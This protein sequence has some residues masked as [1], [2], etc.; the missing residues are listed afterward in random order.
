MMP[1]ALAAQDNGGVLLRLNLSGQVEHDDGENNLRSDIGLNLSSITRNQSFRLG[2]SSGFEGELSDG[3]DAEVED[4]RV[5]L[6]YSLENR[7]TALS[8]NLAFQRSDIDDLTVTDTLTD[9]A[10]VVED[11][12]RQDSSAGFQLELGRENPFGATISLA[13]SETEYQDLSTP[14]T[15][16]QDSERVSGDLTLRFNLNQT[17]TLFTRLSLSDLDRDQGNDIRREALSASLDVELREDLTATADLGYT[18]VITD[19][20]T[21]R[22]ER[23]GIFYGLSLVADR[24][25]GTLSGLLDSDITENGRR[26]TLQ[27][28]RLYELPNGSLS[29]SV[30]ASRNSETNST[31]PL[32][33]F[34]YIQAL[35]RGQFNLDFSQSFSTTTAGLETLDSR[36]SVGLQQE[37][38]TVASLEADLTFRDSNQLNNIGLDT[39]QLDLSLTYAHALT[40]Q[41]DLFGGVSHT[42]REQEGGTRTSDDLLFIGLRTALEWRP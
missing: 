5:T 38:S 18:S 4:P 26:T 3:F 29:A 15:A 30:G 34:G 10:L 8:F 24:P 13:Y 19:G 36:L 7:D 40:D 16:L 32:Y 27:V 31:D 12:E 41:W 22:V 42:R 2:L 39:N 11:G 17:A 1:T 33:S 23:D 20:A 9:T 14:T 25:N 37:L 28:N 6:A 21:S 35:P